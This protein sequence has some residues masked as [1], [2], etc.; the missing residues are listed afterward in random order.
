MQTARR[1]AASVADSRHHRLPAAHFL[2]DRCIGRRAVV[3]FGPQLDVP[4][5]ESWVFM[6][7]FQAVGLAL[8]A[9]IGASVARPRRPTVVAVG[10]GGTYMALQE[11][12]T[13][14]RLK[15]ELL[16]VIYDQDARGLGRAGGCCLPSLWHGRDAAIPVDRIWGGKCRVGT[17]G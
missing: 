8:G 17:R 5:A 11:L 12:E 2:D 15:L 10:D 13:A 14:A 9:G 7:G 1:A 4:D 6:N 3:R 16:V